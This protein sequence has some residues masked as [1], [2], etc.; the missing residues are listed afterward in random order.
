MPS[1]LL[2]LLLARGAHALELEAVMRIVQHGDDRFS[3]KTMVPPCKI[4]HVFSAIQRNLSSSEAFVHGAFVECGV[5][6]G[7]T[8]MAM[9]YA[10][11]GMA[12]PRGKP[13]NRDFWLFD[14]FEGMPPPT[15]EDGTKAHN[16]LANPKKVKARDAAR[17]TNGGDG[18]AYTAS[19]GTKRWN[20]GPR[21]IVEA[22]VKS[23]GVDMN[24][25]HFVQ[26]KVEDTLHRDAPS[27][28]SLPA[29]IALLRLDTDF[30]TST[31][32][33]FAVL[34]PRLVIGGV[35]IVDDYCRWQGARTATDEYLKE[36]GHEFEII[37]D[38]GRSNYCKTPQQGEICFA[39]IRKAAP[40]S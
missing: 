14:T 25:V 12:R 15:A 38:Q 17:W 4:G 20:Y 29:R 34:A 23:T 28:A 13:S 33:E 11:A 7:G 31:K 10:D 24:R 22:N 35:L 19:D 26:G 1:S 18:S 36:H 30:Y 16:K 2:F 3:W 40:R 8:S 39:A 9:I 6:R 37:I 5:W 21:H 32:A 27:F